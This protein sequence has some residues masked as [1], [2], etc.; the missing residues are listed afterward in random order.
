MRAIT[1]G[2]LA[3]LKEL[4]I[5]SALGF[6]MLVSASMLICEMARWYRAKGIDLVAA[7]DTLYEKYGVIQEWIVFHLSC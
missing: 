2:F 3:T 5:T 4:A 6:V 1:F 7:I